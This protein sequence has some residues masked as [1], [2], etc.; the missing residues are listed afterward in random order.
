MG[1]TSTL[2]LALGAAGLATQ[3][4][5]SYQQTQA[6]NQANEWNASIMESQAGNYDMLATDALQ[7]GKSEAAVQQLQA[8]QARAQTRNGYAA[9]GVN[10]NTGSA[11]DVVADMAAWHEYDKQQIISNSEREAWGYTSQANTQRQQA[12]M[13]RAGYTNPYLSVGTS[14][15]SGGTSLWQNYSRY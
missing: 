11:A 4:Y 14:L 10:I 5:A 6:Q 2:G 9:S 1:L 7:R 8:R 3:T 15:I 12:A 13:T